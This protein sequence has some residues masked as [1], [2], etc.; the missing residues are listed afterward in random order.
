MGDGANVYLASAELAAVTA[1]KGKLPTVEEYMN[2]AK[3]LDMVADD[4]YKY[5]NFNE[6]PKYQDIA[7]K[8]VLES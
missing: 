5:L 4:I 7:D 3:N 1:V 8:V 6:L 2:I